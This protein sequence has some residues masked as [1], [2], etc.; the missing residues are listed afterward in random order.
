LP[1]AQ[2][3]LLHDALK[4]AGVPVRLDIL[5]GAGHGDMGT[6]TPI[7]SS[8]ENIVRVVDFVRTTF[9]LPSRP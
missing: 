3:Q 2:S 8:P 7:F 1:V 9:G 5:A 4:Q 6:Q